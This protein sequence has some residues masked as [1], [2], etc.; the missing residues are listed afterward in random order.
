MPRYAELPSAQSDVLFLSYRTRHGREIYFPNSTL[1]QGRNLL[2]VAGRAFIN[3]LSVLGIAAGM[4]VRPSRT[5]LKVLYGRSSAQQYRLG[6]LH[7]YP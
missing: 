4:A 3:V 6:R 5:V 2:Y 7:Q 1:A